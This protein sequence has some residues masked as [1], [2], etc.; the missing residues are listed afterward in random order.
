M[1]TCFKP[2]NARTLGVERAG[3]GMDCPKL[4]LGM[5]L[6]VAVWCLELCGKQGE[7]GEPSHA[8]LGTKCIS[9]AT[10]EIEEKKNNP[11]TQTQPQPG[12]C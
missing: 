2:S 11:K 7:I 8:S 3:K 4:A 5:R 9:I 1:L 10:E 6:S 12:L